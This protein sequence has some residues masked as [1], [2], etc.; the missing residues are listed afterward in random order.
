[1]MSDT[2]PEM[3]QEMTQ[4]EMELEEHEL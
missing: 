3:D 4:S 2:E 1:M